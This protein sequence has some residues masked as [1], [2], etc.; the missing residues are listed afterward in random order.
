MN[1][2][3]RREAERAI[4]VQQFQL[5]A[6]RGA[7]RA[8]EGH[9]ATLESESARQSADLTQL[10][11][12]IAQLYSEAG[13]ARSGVE[14]LAA[15][16][17]ADRP[18]SLAAETRAVGRGS[19]HPSSNFA[20]PD[21][22][23]N[24]DAYLRNV[25][26]YIADH[27]IEV[28][29]DPLSQLMP[30]YLAAEIRRRFDAEF[31]P[32]RWDR[33]DYGVVALA[34]LVGA[35]TDY[36]LVA[37]PGGSFKG[38]P[39]RGSSLTAWMKEQSKKLAPMSGS[40]DIERNAFQLWVAELTTAAEKWAKVPYDVVSPKVGLTPNVHRLASLGHNPLLGLVF[41]VPDII[42]GNCTFIDKSGAWRV[43]DVP[44][45]DGTTNML[46]A[47]VKVLVHGFS[48]VFTEQG[49]PPP[50]LAPFQ[51]VSAKSG[52]TLKEGGDTASVRDVARYMYSNGYDL[53]HFMTMKISP[54]I[55]EV[56]LW[57]YHGVRACAAGSEP[58]ESG[59]ADRL[60]REQM[61]ALTHGLLASTNILKTALYGWNPMAINLAQ[62]ETLAR[63]ML[64]LVK[65][66]AERDRLL[67]QRLD[68]GW[69]AL[70]ATA[71]F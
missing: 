32:A 49:L 29:R 45:H 63:R 55:A 58:G 65:L 53:R 62:F 31:N 13:L 16:G 68:D 2:R 11:K 44:K 56:V 3:T 50:F 8:P 60:K 7:L 69:E 39:Q 51:L 14:E 33:W 28:T 4:L 15:D 41:G 43:I 42:C 12:Q 57:A 9:V 27:G 66:A 22:A 10:D 36:L 52:F 1:K 6:L 38:Q 64:S 25:E 71:Q 47:I 23:E 24:W 17:V 18:E 48:D 54:A 30:P 35:V 5:E 70:L 26:R 67:R 40:G 59:I 20:A 34:V 46:E 37:T 19:T 61:L 21:V